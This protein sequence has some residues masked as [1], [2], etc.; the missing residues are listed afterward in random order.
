MAGVDGGA[1]VGGVL[2]A[3]AARICAGGGPA[4]GAAHRDLDAYADIAAWI[5]SGGPG[6]TDAPAILGLYAFSPSRRVRGQLDS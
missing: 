6:V 3:Q 5:E 2:R 1:G 4:A